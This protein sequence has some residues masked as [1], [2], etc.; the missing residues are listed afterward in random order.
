ML[1]KIIC[2]C[3]GDDGHPPAA[4]I[5]PPVP[6]LSHL[7]AL[8]PAHVVAGEG[9]GGETGGVPVH[10]RAQD[11]IPDLTPGAEARDPGE[12]ETGQD[13]DPSIETET[14]DDTHHTGGQGP[15]LA[16]DRAALQG[17]VGTA[18]ATVH[19]SL[20]VTPSTAPP[21]PIEGLIPPP[22]P[23]LTS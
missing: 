13:L 14:R 16:H 5:P 23:C 17:G 22:P 10:T 21:L 4:P 18:E 20:L 12:E 1:L 11:G 7:L 8:H 2:L 9:M 6:R 15:I 3:P 19:L